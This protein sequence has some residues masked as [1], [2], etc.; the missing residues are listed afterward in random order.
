[1]K[2][3]KT[4]VI[5]AIFSFVLVAAFATAIYNSEDNVIRR[6]GFELRE[7]SNGPIDTAYH[8]NLTSVNL[9]DISTLQLYAHNLGVKTI[10]SNIYHV[11]DYT[12]VLSYYFIAGNST[13]YYAQYQIVSDQPFPMSTLWPFLIIVG[14]AGLIILLG[15]SILSIKSA[16]KDIDN[17]GVPPLDE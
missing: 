7:Q 11:T 12:G 5:F 3:K 2:D 4:I 10:Y 13:V 6:N 17:N 1:M 16:S 14:V 8:L 9:T 15:V